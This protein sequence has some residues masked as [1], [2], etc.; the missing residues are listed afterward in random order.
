MVDKVSKNKSPLGPKRM[1]D[2]INRAMQV[3]LDSGWEMETKTLL[4]YFHSGDMAEGRAAFLEKRT[5][6]FKGK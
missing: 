3:D 2:L 5:P 1:K 4:S 6:N